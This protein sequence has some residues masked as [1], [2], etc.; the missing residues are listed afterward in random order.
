[1]RISRRPIGGFPWRRV[2]RSDAWC[3]QFD[4]TYLTKRL[5]QTKLAGQAGLVGPAWSPTGE[6][7]A[8]L[9]FSALTRD[10]AK[11]PAAPLMLECLVWNPCESGKNKCFSIASMPMAL[12]AAIKDSDHPVRERSR[13]K[14]V[15][16]LHHVILSYLVCLQFS[17][18]N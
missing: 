8:F 6:D 18:N 11:T 7:P 10:S 1:M 4:R 9:P 5:V 16:C 17:S 3:F 15:V 2:S 13:G 14:W 12:K